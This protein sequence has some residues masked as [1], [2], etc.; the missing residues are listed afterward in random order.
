M[1]RDGKGAAP[2]GPK[3]CVDYVAVDAVSCNFT[4]TIAIA[5]A[6]AYADNNKKG[7]KEQKEYSARTR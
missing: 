5:I 7:A 3:L 1:D 4:F 6:I 2:R